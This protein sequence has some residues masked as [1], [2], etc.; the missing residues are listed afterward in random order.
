MVRERERGRGR[1]LLYCVRVDLNVS[2]RK[3]SRARVYQRNAHRHRHIYLYIYARKININTGF[4][5]AVMAVCYPFTFIKLSAS[6]RDNICCER[7]AESSHC[8]CKKSSRSTQRLTQLTSQDTF[9]FSSFCLPFHSRIYW[10]VHPSSVRRPMPF[11]QV[12]SIISLLRSRIPRI[13]N[14]YV[15][16]SFSSRFLW[17]RS[18]FSIIF[19][20]SVCPFIRFSSDSFTSRSERWMFFLSSHIFDGVPY[21]SISLLINFP[22]WIL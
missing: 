8:E 19:F 2:I 9:P 7:E 14:L 16:F 6:E 11:R 21:C 17:L 5:S 15:F 18:S 20:S 10:R 3:H 1:R 22:L 13:E 12:F 4:N